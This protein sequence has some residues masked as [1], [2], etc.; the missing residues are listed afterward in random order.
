[1]IKN[2]NNQ[3]AKSQVFLV[4]KVIKIAVRKKENN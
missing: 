2:E 4:I 3:T 1:M